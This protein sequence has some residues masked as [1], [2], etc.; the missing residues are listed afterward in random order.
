MANSNTIMTQIE[1]ARICCVSKQLVASAIKS[2]KITVNGKR[3]VI[4][5]DPLTKMWMDKKLAGKAVPSEKVVTA[6]NGASGKKVVVEKPLAEIKLEEEIRKIQADIKLKDLSYSQKRNELIDREHVAGVLFSFLDALNINI[7]A[8][9]DTMADVLVD[10]IKS[11]S[12]KADIVEYMRDVLGSEIRNTKE[13]I[14]NRLLR[15]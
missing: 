3:K 5:N 11:G 6:T 9:P 10:R 7:L 13:Q 14:K 12:S 1:F 15:L 4:F 8:A 2:K